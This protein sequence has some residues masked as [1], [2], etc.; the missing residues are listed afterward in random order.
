MSQDKKRE[1]FAI[2]ITTKAITVNYQGD[3]KTV[4]KEDSNYDQLL[5]AIRT[6]AW[7]DIPGLLSPAA[8]VNTYSN[9]VMSVKG[10]QVSI[11]TDTGDFLVPEGLNETILLYMQEKLPFEPL[12]KFAVNLSKNPSYRSAQQLFK[13]IEAN[14][15]TI[16][17]DGNFI[18]YK[19]VREDFKD[20]KT[21]KIDNSVGN[22]VKMPRNEVNEDPQ[23]TCSY[24]LHAANY[25]YAHNI[26][27][28][29]ITL[30][31]EVNP[32]NVVSVPI[33]YNSAKMRVC[34]YK[35]LGISKGEFKERLYKD[36]DSTCDKSCHDDC[37][38]EDIDEDDDDDMCPECDYHV[39]HC[40]CCEHCGYY[41]SDCYHGCDVCGFNICE[42]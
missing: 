33:D 32:A 21:G 9:G 16:T 39:D 1:D 36:P 4:R 22:V 12:V 30:F 26:Y 5:T 31:V 15:L 19:S 42:C 3:S 20:C 25:Y 38:D 40:K 11:K 10:N 27:G 6:E 17:E 35:V 29:A 28:G 2:L 34:E 13:F 23:Q 24:G 7:N 8:A 18:A 41:G 14:H 37:E